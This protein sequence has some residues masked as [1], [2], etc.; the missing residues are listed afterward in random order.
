MTAAS[1]VF[2]TA[3]TVGFWVGIRVAEARETLRRANNLR[4]YLMSIPDEEWRR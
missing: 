4:T 2:A 3:I 1:A